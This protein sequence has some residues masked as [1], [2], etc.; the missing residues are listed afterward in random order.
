MLNPSAGAMGKQRGAVLYVAIVALVITTLAGISLTG[1]VDTATVIAGNL[2][3]QQAA[4]LS[5]ET[6][7][8]AAVEWIQAQ[9]N[10]APDPL[11]SNQSQS[12]GY[13]AGPFYFMA[14]G[15]D[16]ARKPV[17]GQSWNAFWTNTWGA[18]RTDGPARWVSFDCDT[19]MPDPAGACDR[20]SAGNTIS[21]IVQ[22]LCSQPGDPNTVPCVRPPQFQTHVQ[23]G[24][25]AGGG[26]GPPPGLRVGVYYRV[27]IRVEGPHNTLNYIEAFIAL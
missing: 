12:A 22:R 7:V 10:T 24:G 25:S 26:A 21:Y 5:A 23:T 8:E 6:G 3:F 19:L 13:A 20:D 18:N 4:T 17:A 14:D 1:S 27:I 2:A 16:V 15:G 11:R 9:G